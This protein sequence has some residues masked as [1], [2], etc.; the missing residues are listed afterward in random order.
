MPQCIPLCAPVYDI[1]LSLSLDL[2][3]SWPKIHKTA[4]RSQRQEY[5]AQL[6]NVKSLNGCHQNKSYEMHMQKQNILLIYTKSCNLKTILR[7]SASIIPIK[8]QTHMSKRLK[9]ANILPKCKIPKRFFYFLTSNKR[10]I[11]IIFA[12]ASQNDG[13]INKINTQSKNFWNRQPIS[14]S[15]HSI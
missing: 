12:H 15:F 8:S 11:F 3:P 10:P 14:L 2:A 13:R 5:P 6:A 9:R 4:R 7:Q 1:A